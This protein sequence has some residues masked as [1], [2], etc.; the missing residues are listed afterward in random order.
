LNVTD[1]ACSYYCPLNDEDVTSVSRLIIREPPLA[2]KFYLGA[3]EQ[4]PI[5]SVCVIMILIMAII[6]A[7]FS[8]AEIDR[9][10]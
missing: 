2:R 4:L 3:K 9:F 8:L 10:F 7:P 5:L 6:F 1:V